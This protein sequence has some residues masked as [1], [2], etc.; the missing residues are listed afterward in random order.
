M[1]V[2]TR[3]AKKVRKTKRAALASS[4]VKSEPLAGKAVRGREWD[5]AQPESEA[6]ASPEIREP[7]PYTSRY[8][9]S[10]EAFET[11]KRAAPKSKL[12]KPTA[13]RVKDTR[14]KKVEMSAALA[15]AAPDFGSR[16]RHPWRSNS[17]EKFGQQ[18]SMPTKPKSRLTPITATQSETLNLRVRLS[19]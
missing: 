16:S 18:P 15:A 10:N 13:E 12:A 9:I 19:D 17:M 6:P 1:A 3:T 11:L 2:R 7:R 8:P 4:G 14:G 5:I